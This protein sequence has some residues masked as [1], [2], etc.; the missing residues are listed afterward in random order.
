MKKN[1]I[2]AYNLQEREQLIEMIEEMK[3]MSI[4]L[5]SVILTTHDREPSTVLRALRS[6]ENQT[7]TNIEV[8][9]VDDS[10]T[11]FLLRR[12]VISAVKGLGF[13]N[14]RYIE[15]G[16]TVG[17]CASRNLGI[18]CSKGEYIALLDD[19]DEWLPE[20][21]DEQIKAFT[22]P[23]V[24]MVSCDSFYC[25]DDGRTEVHVS[26]VVSDHEMFDE[27]LAGYFAGGCSFLIFRRECFSN[28]GLFKPD[29]PA[30]QDYEMALRVAL[31]YKIR[32]VKKPL[33]KYHIHSGDSITKNTDKKAQAFMIIAIMY[34]SYLKT[35][36]DVYY[37][38]IRKAIKISFL[39]N[40]ERS[41]SRAFSKMI[42]QDLADS[43]IKKMYFLVATYIKSLLQRFKRYIYR[44]YLQ[45]CRNNGVRIW[46]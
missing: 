21:I 15:N 27:L 32:F 20:K 40:N 39:S 12:E 13:S 31:K 8:I 23:G 26:R 1:Y 43:K 5:V 22:D 4:P 3:D 33:L 9:V 16:S 45:V 37:R 10:S 42:W 24:G 14:L 2:Y 6:I 41:K 38:F 28:C 7:Y 35:H 36:P 30:A 25:Y 17:A 29:M 44:I 18:S 19:D 34:R 46:L 11:E